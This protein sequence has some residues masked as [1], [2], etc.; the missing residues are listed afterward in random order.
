MSWSPL[1]VNFRLG[2]NVTCLVNRK[3]NKANN[4]RVAPTHTM[5]G[6]IWNGHSTLCVMFISRIV[7]PLE[8][9]RRAV[10]TGTGRSGRVVIH[11]HIDRGLRKIV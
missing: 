3:L 9:I 5:A 8:L 11:R 6:Y 7:H 1:R 2:I 4:R 10:V